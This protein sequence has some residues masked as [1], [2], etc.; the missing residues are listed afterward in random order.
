MILGKQ[1]AVIQSAGTALDT[2]LG[3]ADIL[4]VIDR[5]QHVC[6]VGIFRQQDPSVIVDSKNFIPGI[7]FQIKFFFL[8]T[9]HNALLSQAVITGFHIL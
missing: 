3:L 2:L 6:A 7:F 1:P 4:G 8:V 5:G 9:I